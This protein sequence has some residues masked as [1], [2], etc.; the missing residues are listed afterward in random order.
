MMKPLTIVAL[1]FILVATSLAV[2]VQVDFSP[3]G[4]AQEAVIRELDAAKSEVLMQAYSFTSA[5]IA[6]AMVDAK[7]CGVNVVTILDKSNET[8]KYSGLTFLTNNHIPTYI[9]YRSAIAHSKIFI[10]DRATIITG[11]FNFTKVAEEKNTENLLVIKND[12]PLVQKYLAN[13]Q[14]R[15]SLSRER[16]SLN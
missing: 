5:P 7:K 12:R 9:D 6:K 13:F 10:I 3:D 11:S 4:G 16:V 8:G 1:T 2:D 15:L 14:N